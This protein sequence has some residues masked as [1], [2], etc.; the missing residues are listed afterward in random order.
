MQRINPYDLQQGKTY[1]IEL[2]NDSLRQYGAYKNKHYGKFI[3]FSNTPDICSGSITGI[4]SDV[5]NYTQGINNTYAYFE[6]IKNINVSDN[7]SREENGYRAY[8][9]ISG[10]Y[11]KFYKIQKYDIEKRITNSIIQEITGEVN[12][13]YI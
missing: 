3:N 7:I 10:V 2:D 9:N 11:W 6:N 1:Y 12:F 5:L 13:D 4:P 8:R